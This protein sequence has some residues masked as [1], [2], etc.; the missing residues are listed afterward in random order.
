MKLALRKYLTKFVYSA[1]KI[2]NCEIDDLGE[3][4]G[5]REI[6]ERIDEC[7]NET[8]VYGYEDTPKSSVVK[9]DILLETLKNPELARRL[10]C[11]KVWTY[12]ALKFTKNYYKEQD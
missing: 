6:I 8:K 7:Q 4:R 10:L 5:Q 2:Y 11:G 9:M 1:K 12:D 3:V